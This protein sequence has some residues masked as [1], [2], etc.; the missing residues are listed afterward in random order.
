MTRE[1]ILDRLAREARCINVHAHVGMDP[2]LYVKGEYPYGM[3]AEDMV[4]RMD[5]QDIDA[6]AVFPMVYTSYFRINAFRNG[7][8]VRDPNGASAFPYQAEN[9]S[10]LKEVYEAFPEFAGRL[11]PF[12]FFD[13]ARRP[14]EQAASLRELAAE[15]PL[16]GLKT[17]TSYLQSP[18]TSLLGRGSCLL[19]LAAELDLPVTIHTAVLPGDPWGNVFE[20]LKVVR[21]RPDVRFALAHTC[22][23]DRRALEAVD[24]LPNGYVDVSA[25]VIHCLLARENHPAVAAEAHRHPA[26]YARPAD[27]LR[28]FAEAFPRTLLWGTDTPMYTYKASFFDERG[29]KVTMD[30]ACGPWDEVRTLRALPDELIDRIARRNV[31][32]YLGAAA[33][34]S[35]ETS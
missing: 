15:Y 11:L 4:F 5:A 31:L 9:L 29:R 23:F 21:A 2:V 6:T 24:S 32:R 28:T 7:R 8:Y 12:A 20:I 13:P 34:D 27:A 17:A 26:D 30:L 3:T 1:Q 10:L 19:D 33:G 22:R 25:F 35:P 14:A 16:M 18:I